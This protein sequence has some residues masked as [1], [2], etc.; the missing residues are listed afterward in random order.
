MRRLLNRDL[1]RLAGGLLGA[2]AAAVVTMG[3]PALASSRQGGCRA[4]HGGVCAPAVAGP[5]ATPPVGLSPAPVAAPP[6]ITSIA[7]QG[8]YPVVTWSLPDGQR[9][10]YI[11]V[12][13]S[14]AADSIGFFTPSA[15][16]AFAGLAP[17]QT[18]YTGSRRLSPGTYYARVWSQLDRRAAACPSGQCVPVS[19]AVV[20][21]TIAQPAPLP[22]LAPPTPRVFRPARVR[23]SR[24]RPA[25]GRSATAGDAYALAQLYRNASEATRVISAAAGGPG[26]YSTASRRLAVIAAHAR[27]ALAAGP[28]TSAHEPC[29]RAILSGQA[30]GLDLVARGF[31]ALAGARTLVEARAANRLTGRGL[32]TIGAGERALPACRAAMGLPRQPAGR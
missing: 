7:D 22:A 32:A 4:V 31:A 27:S 12:A 20:A 5:A 13:S 30:Y 23:P 11:Q 1:R 18:T 25:P 2:L 8:G 15:V 10:R 28:G 16:V 21:F 24:P 26:S 19:S 6:V 3:Q 29:L 14:P 9:S 17:S